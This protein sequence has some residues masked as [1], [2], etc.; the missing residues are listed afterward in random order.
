[1]LPTILILSLFTTAFALRTTFTPSKLSARTIQAWPIKNFACPAGSPA[2]CVYS[3]NLVFMPTNSSSPSPFPEPSIDTFCNGTNIQTAPH[4][5]TDVSVS[6]NLVNGAQSSTLVVTHM[7][8]PTLSDGSMATTWVVGNFTYE[9][10]DASGSYDP[11]VEFEVPRTE[12][13]AVA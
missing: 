6:T 13:F 7:W 2:G 12:W 4:A 3:F 8:H 11:P 5:C 10:P 1:M 9:I